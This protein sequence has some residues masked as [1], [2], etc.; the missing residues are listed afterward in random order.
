MLA[1][2]IAAAAEAKRRSDAR[3]KA[4]TFDAVEWRAHAIEWSQQTSTWHA[5]VGG[6]CDE[7]FRESTSIAKIEIVF[8]KIS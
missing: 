7:C 6:G 4:W 2:Q 3:T 5:E 8:Y 1:Q